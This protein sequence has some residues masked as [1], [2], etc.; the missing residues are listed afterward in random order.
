[1]VGR[2]SLVQPLLCYGWGLARRCGP[3]RLRICRTCQRIKELRGRCGVRCDADPLGR[4]ATVLLLLW[5]PLGP[6]KADNLAVPVRV[7][8]LEPQGSTGGISTFSLF[9]TLSKICASYGRPSV[10]ALGFPHEPHSRRQARPF[11]A[12]L[13]A[14]AEVP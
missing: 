9:N 11:G 14:R 3:I 10:S 5:V 8:V 12:P 6:G 7:R 4:D 13:R 1:V 2:R